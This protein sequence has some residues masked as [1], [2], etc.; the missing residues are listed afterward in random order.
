MAGEGLPSSSNFLL[1]TGIVL[2]HLRDD[3]RAHYL[4]DFLEETDR[5]RVSTIT[6]ME[7]LVRCKPHEEED[8][9]IFFERA[10][11]I[12]ISQEIAEKAAFLI[13]QYQ[14]VFGKDNPRQFPD[15]LIAA[16]AWQQGAF[17]VTLNKKHFGKTK[18][19]EFTVQIIDQEADDWISQ[20][21]L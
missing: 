19:K 11:Q 14:A 13:R 2:R 20:L 6:Y 16:T 3:K 15:A 7:I 1:D 17:L 21:K 8:T 18:I 9:R 10:P 4:L 5:I 12:I